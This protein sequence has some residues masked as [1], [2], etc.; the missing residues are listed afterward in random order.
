MADPH[1]AKAQVMKVVL[2]GL[3][4]KQRLPGDSLA[5]G[6]AGG[7]AGAGWLVPGPQPQ[8]P[9]QPPDLAF[10]QAHLLKR[11]PCPHS[12]RCG[13]PRPVVPQ[14]V[15]VHPMKNLPQ[16]LLPRYRKQL[17]E[18]RRLAVEAAVLG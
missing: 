5:I 9:R 11:S 7:E 14:V 15:S 18:Q 12:L 4:L 3:Y 1:L 8:F 16:S 13:R 2:G 6:Y 10:R 17:G